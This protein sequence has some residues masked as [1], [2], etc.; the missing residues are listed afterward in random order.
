[1]KDKLDYSAAEV[2]IGVLFFG[3]AGSAALIFILL[4]AGAIIGLVD[5]LR[6]LI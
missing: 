6:W 1:M 3:C 5:L 2:V 4:M